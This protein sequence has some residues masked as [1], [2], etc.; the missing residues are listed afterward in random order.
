MMA[1]IGASCGQEWCVFCGWNIVIKWLEHGALMAGTWH[2][3]WP[4][5]GAC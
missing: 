2:E 5:I 1:P 4:R 3:K